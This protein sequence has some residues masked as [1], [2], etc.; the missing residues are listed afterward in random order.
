[1]RAETG[2]TFRIPELPETPPAYAANADK[3]AIVGKLSAAREKYSEL[4]GCQPSLLIVLVL[5]RNWRP[6]DLC[7]RRTVVHS[8]PFGGEHG[9]PVFTYLPTACAYL[10]FCLGHLPTV[11][12]FFDSGCLQAAPGS[13]IQLRR[14]VGYKS[15]GQFTCGRPFLEDVV[16]EADVLEDLKG[17]KVHIFK[18]R[19]KKHYRRRT[20]HRQPLTK[21]LVTKIQ[22]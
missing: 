10:M 20:G 18:Y 19:A 14:V 13:K 21:F 16:V 9:P 22:S 5:H 15:N 7:R 11:V 6:S 8:E 3:Y 4:C 1:M 2:P 12:K 17:P